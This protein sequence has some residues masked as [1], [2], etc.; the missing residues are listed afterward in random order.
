M[1]LTP[2]NGSILSTGFFAITICKLTWVN[3]CSETV[4]ISLIKRYRTEFHHI[5]STQIASVC[6]DFVSFFC[7]HYQKSERCLVQNVVYA[8]SHEWLPCQ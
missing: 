3:S 7:F 1:I 8:Y 6:N 4:E 2:L 5:C